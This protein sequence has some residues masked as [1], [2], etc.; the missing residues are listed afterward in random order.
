MTKSRDRKSA[1]RPQRICTTFGHWLCVVDQFYDKE[2]GG[3]YTHW[4]CRHCKIERVS[5]SEQVQATKDRQGWLVG[6]LAL[7]ILWACVGAVE[8]LLM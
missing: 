5:K 8:Y 2:M 1:G 6:L 7:V 3:L 4:R